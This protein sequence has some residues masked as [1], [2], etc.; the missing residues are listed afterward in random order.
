MPT[1]RETQAER[2]KRLEEE[3]AQLEAELA[4]A[5]AAE[6]A[7]AS[8]SDRASRSKKGRGRTIAAVVILVVAALLAPVA[9]LANTVQRVLTD[10]D[11]FVATVSSSLDD[12]AVQDYLANQ[13]V[14]AIREG[15]NLDQATKDL[16][17]GIEQLDISDRAKAA[18]QL[19]EQ[20]TVAGINALLDQ[21]IHRIVASPQFAD[22]IRQSLRLTH[23]QLVLT[24]TGAEGAAITIGPG[25]TINLS[26][27]PI[28]AEVKVNL[29]D[30]GVGIANLIPATD[31]MIPIATVAEIQRLATAYQVAVVVGTW[32]P[33]IVI[34]MFA[35]AVL[36]ARRRSTMLFAAGIVFAGVAGVVGIAIAFGRVVS[37]SALAQYI[38]V[39]ASGPIYDG[40]VSTTVDLVIV[41]VVLGLSVALVAFLAAPWRPS[42]AIRRFGDASADSLAHWAESHG[43]ST[44]GFGDFLRQWRL[45]IRVAIGVIAAAIIIFV[46]PLSPALIIWTLVIA[47]LLVVL[48]R[49][50][51]RPSTLT[52]PVGTEAVGLP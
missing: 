34:L 31:R 32:L 39:S 28:L 11:V 48:A 51:E 47:L 5:R 25:G 18:L 36:I 8:A 26:L 30:A 43:V 17:D 13:I 2:L 16:F 42:R 38:P 29:Q 35:A 12:P 21:T 52:V 45:P 20:P 40:L 44:G 3:N 24:L 9:I 6:Q 33:W 27:G 10:T 49:L 1:E 50:L 4:Q 23:E 7:L 46:R 15:S 37:T 19:L 41:L 22:I 14:V